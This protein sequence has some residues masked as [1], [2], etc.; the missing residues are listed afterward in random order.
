[1]THVCAGR[2]ALCDALA[3]VVRRALEEAATKWGV[4]WITEPVREG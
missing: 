3:I 2:C 4:T 1:M